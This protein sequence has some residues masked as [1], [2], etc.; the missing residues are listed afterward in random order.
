MLGFK[1]SVGIFDNRRIVQSVVRV[2]VI[3]GIQEKKRRGEF[4]WNKRGCLV[5]EI[6]YIFVKRFPGFPY[7]LDT[8]SKQI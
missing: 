6:D 8:N 5:P 3:L 2:V 1:E 4:D 7:F